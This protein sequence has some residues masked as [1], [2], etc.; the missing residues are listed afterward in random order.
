MAKKKKKE[1]EF[2]YY[3]TKFDIG[4]ITD[5]GEWF[6]KLKFESGNNID[7][8]Y[9]NN[10]IPKLVSTD[11]KEFINKENGLLIFKTD[12]KMNDGV[13]LY[14]QKEENFDKPLYTYDEFMVI[15]SQAFPKE[16]FK[17]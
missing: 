7:T 13:L 16:E 1:K 15:L 6:P 4:L 12:D 8:E 5:I 3:Y 9:K 2:I 10:I 17:L 14:K 11:E